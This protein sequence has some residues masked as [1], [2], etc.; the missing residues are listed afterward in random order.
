M[1]KYNKHGHSILCKYQ[2]VFA[3]DA[4]FEIIRTVRL[5]RRLQN[6]TF[7]SKKRV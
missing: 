4:V 2:R 6:I 1:V 3:M 5:T 7:K